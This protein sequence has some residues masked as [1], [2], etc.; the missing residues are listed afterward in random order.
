MDVFIVDN[1]DSFTYN[2]SHLIEK[3]ASKVKVKRN[4]EINLEE[5]EMYDKIV[6][7]PGPGLPS[8]V[9]VMHEIIRKYEH[10]KSILGICLGHQSIGEYYG[11]RLLNMADVDHGLGKKTTLQSESKLYYKIPAEFISGRYHSWIIDKTTIPG[12][13]QVD[14]VDD[15]GNIMG[16]SHKKHKIYGMQFHPES[17]L[18]PPGEQILSNWIDY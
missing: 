10:S 7:S 16:I 5:I 3:Y 11:A 6:F 13:I 9:P 17:I 8:E 15:K 18:T 1:Y 4:D 12:C 14:A 2:L